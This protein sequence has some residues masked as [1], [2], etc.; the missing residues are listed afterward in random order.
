MDVTSD[1]VFRSHPP[2]SSIL[3]IGAIIPKPVV[4]EG[5]ITV[6]PCLKMSLSVDHRAVDGAVAARFLARLME[7][8]ETP[9]LM[10]T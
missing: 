4:K 1:I 6:R 8:V 5:E 2:E 3:A 9:F 10:L 7:L